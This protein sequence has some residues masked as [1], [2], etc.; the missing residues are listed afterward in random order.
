M[1][2]KREKRSKRSVLFLSHKMRF[3]CAKGARDSAL[4]FSLAPSALELCFSSLV[5]RFALTLARS[6][7]SRDA[8]S[9]LF[10]RVLSHEKRC[11]AREENSSLAFCVFRHLALVFSLCSHEIRRISSLEFSCASA[12]GSLAREEIRRGSSREKRSVFALLTRDLAREKRFGIAREERT[13]E[14]SSL[15]S[16]ERSE[17]RTRTLALG[18][19]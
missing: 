12:F 9:L 14:K 16:R 4:E 8:E 19:L 11:G 6:L 13:R 7:F 5:L 17:A 15:F 10:S 1:R 3:S 2:A 18:C